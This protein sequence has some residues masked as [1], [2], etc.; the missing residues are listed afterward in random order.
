MG[1]APYFM[2]LYLSLHQP[3]QWQWQHRWDQHQHT[4]EGL[5]MLRLIKALPGP[6]GWIP[7][8]M[9]TRITLDLSHNNPFA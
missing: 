8:T 4:Y 5:V 7:I 3:E 2:N 6:Q 1:P 9:Q